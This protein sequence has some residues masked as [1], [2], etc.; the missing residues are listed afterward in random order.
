MILYFDI[1][2]TRLKCWAKRNAKTDYFAYEHKADWVATFLRLYTDLEELTSEQVKKVI[3][4][5]VAGNSAEA[6]LLDA[7][8][9]RWG[10]EPVF[11]RVNR[12]S[13]SIKNSYKNLQQLGVDR[14]VAIHG[15][16]DFEAPYIVIDCGTAITV[17]VVNV[18]D[19]DRL[20]I[21]GAI[22]LGFDSARSAL[23]QTDGIA[24][25]V[26]EMTELQLGQTTEDCCLV[27]ILA[28]CVGG[29]ERV[30]AAA[31]R[32]VG[33]V[34]NIIFTGGGAKLLLS[35]IKFD[36]IYEPNLIYN[37]LQRLS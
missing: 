11:I 24:N 15:A 23:S 3:V 28:S 6:G 33:I 34:N 2:N 20:F 13:A 5:N 16:L 31:E 25:N 32:E 36:Y 26:L 19:G 1:G 7:C 30:I 10:I 21:G 27:G 29:I 14:W 12:E 8:L 9:L 17:D 37:G 18:V 35:Q 4:S 22:L